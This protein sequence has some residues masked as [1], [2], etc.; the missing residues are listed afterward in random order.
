M[1]ASLR[2]RL[3]IAFVLV[4]IPPLALLAVSASSL[5]SRS[6]EETARRRLREALASASA[7]LVELRREA[8]VRLTAVARDD[9]ADPPASAAED[10]TVAGVIAVRRGLEAFEIVDDAGRVVSSR[11]WPAGFGLPERDE[12]V[13]D[14]PPLRLATVAQGP[15]SAQRL[16][17]MPSRT[18][19]WRGSAATIRGGR[20]VDADF[21]GDL[22]RSMG[23]DVAFYDATRR[24]WTA[25]AD[26][27]LARWS[28]PRFSGSEAQGDDRL[29]GVAWRWAAGRL[30]ED[31]WLVVA[32]PRTM[33]AA[34]AD[35]FLRLALFA[36]LAAVAAALGAA[37]LLSRRI[38]RPVRELADGAR[39]IAA[40][41]RAG[42]VRA[43]TGGE[44]G[45]LA[46]AF[47]ALG[48]DLDASRARLV[49]AERVAA[50]REMARRLAHELKNPLFPIQLSIETLRR[51]A[52]QD[53]AAGPDG[54]RRLA[55][56]V[57]DSSDTILDELR[58]LKRIVEEFSEFARLP[59]PRLT[60]GDLNATV[61]Q[62]LDLYR[63]RAGEVRLT[64]QLDPRLPHVTFDR[65]LVA[66]ALGNLVANALEAMP[67]GGELRV[68]TALGHGEVRLTVEDSGP[69]LDADQRRR[70]FTP[71]HTT[72]AGG[73][74]LGLAI[75]QGIA[76]D[77]GG[78][79]EVHSEPGQGAS[80][81]LVL[82]LR[83]APPA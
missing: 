49:Q 46:D 16:A 15:A 58:A 78:R 60:P 25:S 14:E 33:E 11:H 38:A 27:P 8:D 74:G 47:N 61:E 75:V 44:I 40:G 17:L 43:D 82:P 13:A 32:A 79:V 5:I 52:E 41:Q 68:R 24:R 80:F 83:E 67:G 55:Q 51:A 18:V 19:R 54:E 26:S 6:F 66:R 7:R 2:A 65:D 10:R 50:W 20:L 69:G 64:A 9:L 63:P 22:G 4:A 36:S 56:L 21:L 45:E 81:T 62:T 77:H 1:K 30:A 34:L 73:T 31:L 71:Y 28:P 72:K 29:G 59:R 53:G 39:R 37:F 70:L 35:K 76:S 12:R 3:L 48:G 57:R 23:V 42:P